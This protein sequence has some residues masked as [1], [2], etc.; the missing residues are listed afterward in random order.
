MG[1]EPYTTQQ[2]TSHDTSRPSRPST[3]PHQAAYASKRAE[4]LFGCYRR[5]DANDPDTYVAA[6][7]A[8]L[9]RYEPDLIREV[10]DPNTGIQTTEKHMTFM[11]NAGELKIYCETIAAR[12]ERLKRL[13]E[14]RIPEAAGRLEAPP[15]S[16]G[17]WANLFVSDA[18]PRYPRLVEWTKTGDPREWKFGKSSDGRNGVWIAL[19][20]W[21]DGQTIG[22]S[23]SKVAREVSLSLSEEALKT[24]RDVDA[25]RNGT[26]PADEAAE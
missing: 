26:T 7:S 17:D 2:R 3:S 9:S 14:R 20:I 5:G 6:I 18:H 22:R 19:R 16:P 10:T 8:I 13:G 21:E 24:M 15:P 4:L 23:A 25:E 12:R 1:D 11:P